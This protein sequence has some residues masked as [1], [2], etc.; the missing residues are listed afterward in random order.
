MLLP[1]IVTYNGAVLTITRENVRSRVLS[2]LIYR[3]FD[4]LSDDIDESEFLLI[5]YFVKFMTQCKVDG[6]IGFAVP[7]PSAHHE[8]ILAAYDAFQNMPAEFFDVFVE[9]Y[10]AVNAVVGDPDTSPTSKKKAAKS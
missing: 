8:V 6:Q 3:H 5:E 2:G 9:G 7:L 1:Q 4:I 10:N